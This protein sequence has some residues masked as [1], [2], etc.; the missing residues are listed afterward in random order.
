MKLKLQNVGEKVSRVRRVCRDVVLRARIEVRFGSRQRSRHTLIL[1]AQLPPRLVVVGGRR[2]RPRTPSTATDRSSRPNG[3][4]ATFC[5]AV[6]SRYSRS[7]FSDGTRS[8]RPISFRYPG[9][10]E[11]AIDVA[12]GLVEG[13]DRA[14]AIEV[15]LLRVQQPVVVVAELVMHDLEVD[16][17]DLDAHLDAHILGRVPSRR[18][19]VADDV[20]IGGLREKRSLPEGRRQRLIAE[21]RE[22]SLGVLHQ[23]AF[24]DLAA[25]ERRGQVVSLARRRCARPAD[26]CC[27]QSCAH[28]L[29][30]RCA[31]IM[32]LAGSTPAP[33]LCR[34]LRSHVGVQG[35][36]QRL[37]LRPEAIDLGGEGVGRHV[38]S[39][40][41]TA[42]RYRRIPARARLCSTARRSALIASRASARRR[43]AIPATRRAAPSDRGSRQECWTPG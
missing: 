37:H 24:V 39:S 30:R 28:M 34:E 33:Y 36:I 35:E 8:M 29:P 1:L 14:V 38:V 15:R 41:A 42:R 25:L 11:S 3:R 9:V 26:R 13:V 6:L 4:N 21:R 43:G 2:S 19:R 12:D 16:R 20:A 18:A 7:P 31:G 22:K 17:V 23:A 10:A 40:S 5:S 27:V 32:P